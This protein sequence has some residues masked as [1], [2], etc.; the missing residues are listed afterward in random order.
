MTWRCDSGIDAGGGGEDDDGGRGSGGSGMMMMMMEAMK[1]WWVG[2]LDAY[3]IA[4]E[5]YPIQK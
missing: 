2:F 5:V 4:R 1:C 3:Y